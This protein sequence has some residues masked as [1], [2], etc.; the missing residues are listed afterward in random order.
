MY[1]IRGIEM[2]SLILHLG[3]GSH[4]KAEISGYVERHS[5][6]ADKARF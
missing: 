2:F 1:K 3:L 6:T 5:L 4:K